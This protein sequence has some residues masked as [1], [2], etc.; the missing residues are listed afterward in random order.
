[1]PIVLQNLFALL[2]GLVLGPALGGAA[3]AVYLVAG[4]IGAPVF[5]GASGGFVHLLGPTGGF[6]YGYLLAAVGAGLIAGYPTTEVKTPVWRI[7]LAAVV[8][9]LIVYVPGLLQ[10]KA[11]LALPW[12]GAFAAGFL[13][14]L[15]GDA[16]KA[17]VA[18]IAAIRL[19]KLTAELLG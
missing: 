6:L 11:V 13:P 4:A 17:A 9:A 8:G 3:V 16:I 2:S 10:L 15:P 7:I 18:V 12:G 5:A 19:R 14:F 1:V